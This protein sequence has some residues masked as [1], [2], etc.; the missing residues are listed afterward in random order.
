M[1][2]SFLVNMERML[3]MA[4]KI[5]ESNVIALKYKAGL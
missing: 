4:I 1:E 2:R 3:V 5:K